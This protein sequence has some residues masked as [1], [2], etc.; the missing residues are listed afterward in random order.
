MRSGR[1]KESVHNCALGFTAA[2]DPRS[3]GAQATQP[4][5]LTEDHRNVVF[6]LHR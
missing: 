6:N 3:L 2:R 1:S 4:E 5:S